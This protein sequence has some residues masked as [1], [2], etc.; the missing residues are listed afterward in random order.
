M[1][2]KDFTNNNFIILAHLYDEKDNN[3]VV[4]TTQ[5]EVAE[6]TGLSRVTINKIFTLLVE[7]GYIVKDARHVGRYVITAMGCK[8]V[9]VFRCLS[10]EANNLIAK[11][12]ISFSDIF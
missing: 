5:D 11:N 8:V 10:V 9:D 12:N 7:R 4:K 2:I 3:G 6:Y 1:V